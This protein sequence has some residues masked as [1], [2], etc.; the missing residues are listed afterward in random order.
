MLEVEPLAPPSCLPGIKPPALPSC[1]ILTEDDK[2]EEINQ[3]FR[4]ATPLLFGRSSS[5]FTPNNLGQFNTPQ[6]DPSQLSCPKER[7][8]RP[9][10]NPWLASTEKS[11]LTKEPDQKT[12]ENNDAELENDT[13]TNYITSEVQP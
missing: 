6:E 8:V 9:G 2:K 1:F 5:Q 10:P 13:D 11:Y 7:P 3:C 12:S 4:L